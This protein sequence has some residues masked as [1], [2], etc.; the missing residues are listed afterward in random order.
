MRFFISY[1][2]PLPPCPLTP[3]KKLSHWKRKFWHVQKNFS[4]LAGIC[5]IL[6]AI[7]SVSTLSS[8][9]RRLCETCETY[10]E[11]YAKL[12]RNLEWRQINNRNLR[13]QNCKVEVL[14]SIWKRRWGFIF[15]KP[16]AVKPLHLGFASFD[17]RQDAKVSFVLLSLT[18]RFCF[19]KF[20]GMLGCLVLKWAKK[21][22]VAF[23][24]TSFNMMILLFLK[25][26][27]SFSI[28][29][30]FPNRLLLGSAKESATGK[31]ET[32]R[33]GMTFVGDTVS[34]M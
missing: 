2:R 4:D 31:S 9:H 14:S 22:E 13:K 26:K 16:R 10:C 33:L 34:A 32:P 18:F 27:L 29:W 23:S 5:H 19:R 12:L 1:F 8:A 20:R 24:R 7:L 30:T 17:W 15:P 6:F 3:R 28:A 21:I 11:T 25:P